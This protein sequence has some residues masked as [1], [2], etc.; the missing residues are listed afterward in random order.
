MLKIQLILSDF[1]GTIFCMYFS[2]A[3]QDSAERLH[4]DSVIVRMLQAAL[5][6]GLVRTT[7]LCIKLFLHQLLQESMKHRESILGQDGFQ[8][9]SPLS[10]KLFQILYQQYCVCEF[11]IFFHKNIKRQIKTKNFKQILEHKEEQREEQKKQRHQKR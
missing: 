4:S 10:S 8:M 2:L 7:E 1:S 11:I 9:S 3:L 5:I 6:I